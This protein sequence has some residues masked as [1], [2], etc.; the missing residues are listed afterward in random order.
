MIN[1]LCV[2][3]IVH[4]PGNNGSSQPSAPVPTASGADTPSSASS[5]DVVPKSHHNGSLGTG[6]STPTSVKADGTLFFECV[7]CSR[8]V[9]CLLFVKTELLELT[10][11]SLDCIEQICTSSQFMHGS[12][13]HS[14]GCSAGKCQVKVSHYSIFSEQVSTKALCAFP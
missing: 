4:V 1:N 12:Q 5:H 3:L 2:L 7:S 8:Q 9:C 14:K 13:H 10:P 6:T 11:F